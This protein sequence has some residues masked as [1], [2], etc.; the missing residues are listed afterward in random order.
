MESWLALPKPL[1]FGREAETDSSKTPKPGAAAESEAVPSSGLG[2]DQSSN[3]STSRLSVRVCLV[4][5]THDP[6]R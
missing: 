3:Q 6:K 4:R 2:W 5:V 1:R